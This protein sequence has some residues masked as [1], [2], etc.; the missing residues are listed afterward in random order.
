MFAVV[1]PQGAIW[2]RRIHLL[3]NKKHTV[4]KCK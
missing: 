2:R 4:N 3:F 1:K